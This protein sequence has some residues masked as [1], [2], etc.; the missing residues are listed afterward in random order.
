MSQHVWRI[1]ESYYLTALFG[2][3]IPHDTI[4]IQTHDLICLLQLTSARGVG[5][6]ATPTATPSCPT[7]V[8][9][10]DCLLATGDSRR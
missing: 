10:R 8:A 7:T 5:V 3:C 4:N 9:R 6:S 2:N 1:S